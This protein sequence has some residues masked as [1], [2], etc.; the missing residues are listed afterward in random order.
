[1]GGFFD[2]GVW[3]R[4][5]PSSAA[6]YQALEEFCLPDSVTTHKNFRPFFFLSEVQ[7]SPKKV[8]KLEHISE[9]AGEKSQQRKRYSGGSFN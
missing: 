1:M 2:G 4:N 7:I 9:E 3:L 5:L 8:K 6:T